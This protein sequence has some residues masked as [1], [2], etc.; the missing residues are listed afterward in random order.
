MRRPCLGNCGSLV[1]GRA[2]CRAC[3]RAYESRRAPHRAA[4]RD[5]A[6]RALGRASGTCHLCGQ[7]GADTWDHVVPLS[8]GGT[9]DY[10]N[11]RPAHRSCNSRKRDRTQ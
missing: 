5:P 9:N 10:A 7:P 11:L 8:R 2:R 3:S 4:Y 1:E 6:Y